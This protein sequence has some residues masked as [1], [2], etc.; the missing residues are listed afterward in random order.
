[1]SER[2]RLPGVHFGSSATQEDETM[3]GRKQ[4]GEDRTPVRSDGG[5]TGT[6]LN[7]PEATEAIERLRS[8]IDQAS[9]AMRDLTQVSEQWAQGL[10]DRAFDMANELRSQGERAVGTVSERVEHNPLASLAVALA[11]GFLCATLIRR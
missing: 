1:V 10:Q 3:W 9:R 8:G 4:E 7:S 5:G 11:V 2:F 6:L